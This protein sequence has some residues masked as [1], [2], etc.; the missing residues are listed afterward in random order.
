MNTRYISKSY[1]TKYKIEELPKKLTVLGNNK[2]RMF[3]ELIDKLKRKNSTDAINIAVELHVS[4]YIS[5]L[6][7]KIIGYYI[8]NINLIQPRGILYISKFYKYYSIYTP[9]YIRKNKLE[10]INNLCVRNFIV[11]M[12]TLI[13]GSNE[14]KLLSLKKIPKEDF[15]MS[16]HKNKMF[17]TDLNKVKKF[18]RRNDPKDI[19]I[20]MSEIITCLEDERIL[21]REQKIIYWISWLMEYEKIYHDGNLEIEYRDVEYIE[22]KYSIDFLWIIWEMLKTCISKEILVYINNLEYIYKQNFTR[23]CRRKRITFLILAILLYINPMPKIK[24]PLEPIEKTLLKKMQ[25]ETLL[26]NIRYLEL[27]RRVEIQNIS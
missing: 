6:L 19:I 3:K 14:R 15:D 4:G 8:D 25:Y 7:S 9:K 16:R 13:C 20:P 24:I 17:S 5:T 1:L 10:I 27:Y 21:D 26:I 2:I 23:G 12:I 11:N 18:L 22:N